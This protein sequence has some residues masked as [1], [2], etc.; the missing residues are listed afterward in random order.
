M[1][2]TSNSSLKFSNTQM[3]NIF[4]QAMINITTTCGATADCVQKY[5]FSRVNIKRFKGFELVNQ[6]SI[7]LGCFDTSIEQSKLLSDFAEA[8]TKEAEARGFDIPLLTGS[9][10][11]TFTNSLISS[12]NSIQ[13]SIG[14]SCSSQLRAEIVFTVNDANVWV[15]RLVSKIK[16]KSFLECVFSSESINQLIEKS[17]QITNTS[18]KQTGIDTGIIISIIIFIVVIL[19]VIIVLSAVFS[20]KK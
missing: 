10:I 2:N 16:S 5:F 18:L 4:Q 9:D 14:N 3:Y 6:C 11:T 8:V 17:T 1:G 7:R 13:I 15:D 19:I 12:F 20:I